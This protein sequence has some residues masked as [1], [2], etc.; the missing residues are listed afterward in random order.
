VSLPAD[1][2]AAIYASIPPMHCKGLCASACTLIPATEGEIAALAA[3]CPD[4]PNLGNPRCP[5][6]TAK[7]RCAAYSAR[8]LI[9]RAYGVTKRMRCPHGC[10]PKRWL[11][12]QEFR[13]LHRR[14]EAIGGQLGLVNAGSTEEI[15]ESLRKD[16]R[17]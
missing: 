7:G 2:L 3:A 10:R 8:P 17:Q 15:I 4:P 6:L 5:Y 12:D 1:S 11:T 13:E 9:C 16:G 14:V